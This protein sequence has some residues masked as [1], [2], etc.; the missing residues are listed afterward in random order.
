MRNARNDQGFERKHN[1]KQKNESIVRGEESVTPGE[2]AF[3]CRDQSIPTSSLLRL[4]V[5]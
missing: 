1:R 5:A 2:K 4:A 3:F